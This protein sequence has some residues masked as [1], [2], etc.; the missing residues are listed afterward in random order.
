[1]II[2]KS[3]RV[4]ERGQIVIPKAIRDQEGIKPN[5]LLEIV[6]IAGEIKIKARQQ[7]RKNPEDLFLEALQSAHLTR[8][9]WNIIRKERHRE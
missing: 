6:D 7:M 2:Q 4:G 9:D 1:M 8:E 5:Q 3:I